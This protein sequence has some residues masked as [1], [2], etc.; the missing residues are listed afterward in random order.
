M[1]IKIKVD[2]SQCQRYGQCVFEAPQVFRLNDNDELEY[3]AE[4]DDSERVRWAA[5]LVTCRRDKDQDPSDN[6][7]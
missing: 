6:K 1:A 4:A 7:Y 5:R 3:A 2:M